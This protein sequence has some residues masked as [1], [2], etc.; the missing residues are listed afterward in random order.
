MSAVGASAEIVAF[1]RLPTLVP[2]KRTRE[3]SQGGRSAE[4]SFRSGRVFALLSA[5]QHWTSA[6][7]DRASPG[8]KTL[9]PDEPEEVHSYRMRTAEFH[10]SRDRLSRQ[11]SAHNYLGLRSNRSVLH[12]DRVG[13][14]ILIIRVWE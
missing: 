12:G 11:L 7:V 8:R 2:R 4:V 1:L 14:Q 3:V 13:P 10:K 5:N 9:R 6:L